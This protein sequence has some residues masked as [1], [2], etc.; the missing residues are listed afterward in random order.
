MER[1]HS[2]IVIVSYAKIGIM[3]KLINKD[4]TKG[5]SNERSVSKT[6]L[7]LLVSYYARFSLFFSHV[8]FSIYSQT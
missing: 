3:N 1:N 7:L 8:S 5:S 2:H 6:K 4:K